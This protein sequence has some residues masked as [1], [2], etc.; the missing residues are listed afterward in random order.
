MNGNNI[1]AQTLFLMFMQSASIFQLKLKQKI[2][3][4]IVIITGND[5]NDPI[6][7]FIMRVYDTLRVVK[8]NQCVF[9]LSM[10]KS[11]KILFLQLIFYASYLCTNTYNYI[12][13]I[14]IY[15]YFFD[16]FFDFS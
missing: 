4:N 9:S 3:T 6:K 12:I 1:I 14:Y 8:K 15:T 7:R 5:R 11:F 16:N 13:D 10:A 2:C